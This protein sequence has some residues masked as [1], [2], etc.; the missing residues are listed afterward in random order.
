MR[1]LRAELLVGPPSDQN[2]LK[3]AGL[4]IVNPPWTLENELSALLPALSAIL[5]PNARAVF[6]APNA[7]AVFGWTGLP[8]APGHGGSMASFHSPA[9][10]V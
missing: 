5:G 3:G 8:A 10:G 7:R 9:V 1:A 6:W 4:V 2:R